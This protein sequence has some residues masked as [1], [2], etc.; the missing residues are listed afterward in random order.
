MGEYVGREGN[1]WVP[2]AA[3]AALIAVGAPVA[4][5]AADD[6]QFRAVYYSL[7]SVG[8]GL[9]CWWWFARHRPVVRASAPS[10]ISLACVVEF[11]I[12]LGASVAV[13]HGLGAWA[14]LGAALL[15]YGVVERARLL[16]T[17]GVATVLCAVAAVVVDLLAV[18]VA[19]QLV[20]AVFCALAARRLRSALNPS[21]RPKQLQASRRGKS[22]DFQQHH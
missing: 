4:V 15:S 11:A 22:S 9:V 13:L 10:Y 5:V 1:N 21:R 12:F 3:L 16:M 20:N 19:L 7:A 2:V 8:L 18:T 6:V 17:L 14:V